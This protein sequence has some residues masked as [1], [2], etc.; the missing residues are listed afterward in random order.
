MEG[1]PDLQHRI[2]VFFSL[3]L[4]RTETNAKLAAHHGILH[5]WALK[6]MI[7]FHNGQ[8]VSNKDKFYFFSF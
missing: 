3:E 5:A 7:S 1:T 4:E 6:R 2:Y 8:Q